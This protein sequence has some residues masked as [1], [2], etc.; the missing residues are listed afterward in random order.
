MN[1][2]KLCGQ[3]FSCAINCAVPSKQQGLSL[4]AVVVTIILYLHTTKHK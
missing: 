4:S 3:S 1:Q 2:P